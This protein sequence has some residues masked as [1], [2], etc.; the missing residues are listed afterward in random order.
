MHFCADEL[1]ALLLGAPY[2]VWAWTR[3]RGFFT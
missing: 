1:Q 2:L 3:L